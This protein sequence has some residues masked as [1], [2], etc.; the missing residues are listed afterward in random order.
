MRENGR[1]ISPWLRIILLK[2]NLMRSNW[3]T[4]AIEDQESSTGCSLIN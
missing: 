1:E 4:I 3:F 2:L